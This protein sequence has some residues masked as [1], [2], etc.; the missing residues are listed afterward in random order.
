MSENEQF[1]RRDDKF[2]VV[3]MGLNI[4]IVIIGFFLSTTLVSV[5]EQLKQHDKAITQ[6]QTQV[7]EREKARIKD[8][9]DV[10]ESL[11]K[12]AAELKES[13]FNIA[14]DLKEQNQATVAR[15]ESWLKE[16]SMKVDRVSEKVGAK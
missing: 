13:T 12:T 4:S 11:I 2:F 3:K 9:T 6:M 5:N 8:S 10:R 15:L 7:E 14:R 16:L 1:Q